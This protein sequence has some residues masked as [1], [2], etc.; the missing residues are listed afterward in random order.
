VNAARETIARRKLAPVA[1]TIREFRQE[2]FAADAGS[3]LKRLLGLG[4]FYAMSECRDLVFHVQEHQYRLPQIARMLEEQGLK[5]IG[6]SSAV[7]AHAAAEYRKMFPKDGGMADLERWDAVEARH[8]DAF[9]GM[10]QVWC[11][12]SD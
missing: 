9:I 2:V 11:Q 1:A 5:V 7:P 4:D 8:P 10:Y 6:I 3:P 12:R